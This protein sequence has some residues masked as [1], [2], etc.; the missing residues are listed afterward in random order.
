MA[1]ITVER[2]IHSPASTVFQTIADPRLFAQAIEGVTGV[3]VLPG[4]PSGAGLR[5]RQSRTIGGRSGTMDFEITEAVPDARV[6]IV[7]ETH[8]TVWDSVFSLAP[9]AGGT[10]LT[11]RMETRSQRLLPRLMM[12]IVCLMIRKAVAKDIDGVKAFCEARA[13]RR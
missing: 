4:V 8:G 13:S 5:F 2:T 11:M 10:E 6:R 12:P 9:S 7:N 3:E 1:T